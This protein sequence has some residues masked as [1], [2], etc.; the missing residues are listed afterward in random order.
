LKGIGT[1][2]PHPA[3]NLARASAKLEGVAGIYNKYRYLP[4]KAVTLGF[5]GECLCDIWA[6]S[7]ATNPRR[8]WLCAARIKQLNM[9]DG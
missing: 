4:E 8:K 2:N 7:L 5:W 6:T 1:K 9:D 3:P